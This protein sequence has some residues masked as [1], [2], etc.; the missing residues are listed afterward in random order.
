MS[1]DF[2][3]EFQSVVH[4]VAVHMLYT[5]YFIKR[6]IKIIQVTVWCYRVAPKSQ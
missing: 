2:L 5:T 1:G 3:V 6:H 4:A